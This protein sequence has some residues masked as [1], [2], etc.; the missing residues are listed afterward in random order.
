MKI[1]VCRLGY[2]KIIII[3]SGDWYAGSIFSTADPTGIRITAA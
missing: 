2:E 3:S 1:R